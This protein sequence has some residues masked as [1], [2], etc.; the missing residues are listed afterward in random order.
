MCKLYQ[1]KGA[2]DRYFIISVNETEKTARCVLCKGSLYPPTTPS[3]IQIEIPLELPMCEP[4]TVKSQMEAKLWKLGSG[5]SKV[6]DEETLLQMFVVSIH[7]I[8]HSLT[9][10]AIKRSIIEFYDKHFR[11]F[12]LLYL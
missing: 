7:Q 3:P 6:A 4:D 5:I 8:S 2:A 1:C 9:C 11:C 12:S 10:N